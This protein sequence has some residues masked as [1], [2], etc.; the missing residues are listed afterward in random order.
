MPTDAQ[1]LINYRFTPPDS[2]PVVFD[3][4]FDA[5]SVTLLQDD[6]TP[7]DWT[8]LDQNR[9]PN[10]PLK[11]EQ[12]TYCPAA[13][14]L[15]P[16][17]ARFEH[18][19]SHD[20]VFLEVT[21]AERTISGQT[22]I[23]RAVSSLMGLLL[24]ASNCPHT[25]FFKPM[26]RFHLPLASEEETIYRATSTYMLTQ[27]FQKLRG[28]EPDF[29]LEE[30]NRIYQNIHEVNRTMAQR[31]R[32]ASTTDSSINAIILLDMYAKAMPYAIKQALDEISYL[33]DA[34]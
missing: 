23:Q 28:R 4:R 20:R 5:R 19:L 27:Y 14:A 25:A 18:L 11:P 17:V 29:S 31:L 30:L 2:A 22:T 21:T 10:C 9:C 8:R 1:F 16:L 12:T 15:V 32:Q 13:L 6:F 7:P 3:L 26:A 24:A 34:G 33:F